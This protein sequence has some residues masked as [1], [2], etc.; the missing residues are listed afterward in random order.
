MKKNIL[1]FILILL[2]LFLT[3]ECSISE[4]SQKSKYNLELIQS[5]D[6]DI[7]EPS[8]LCFNQNRTAL[9]TVNDPPNNKIYK[10][11][12][13]G[14]DI[15]ELSYQGEDLEGITFDTRDSTLWIVDESL[16]QVVNLDTNGTVIDS[17]QIDFT[18][19]GNSGFEG[20][21][22]NP[23]NN[24]FYILNEKDPGKFLEL[25]S[26]FN[27]ITQITLNFANDYSGIF[28]DE[29]SGNCY[30]VSD[31][32]EKLYIWDKVKGV[33]EEIHL[34][35]EQIEGVAF[36]SDNNNIY[37]VSDAESKL[38]IYKLVDTE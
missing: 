4:P 28:F 11:K 23:Q 8:G 16:L 2:L 34:G 1:L 3:L 30:I 17:F 15:E 31:E 36:N 20:L 27:I 6:I 33:I 14:T 29:T 13:D 22:F 12:L 19:N 32:S 9:F 25:D 21:T 38:Y 18:A 24:H 35:K 10:M 5:I 37:F 7:P 26:N